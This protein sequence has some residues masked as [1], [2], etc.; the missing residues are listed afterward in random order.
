MQSA[1]DGRAKIRRAKEISNK[2]IYRS[3][4][5]SCVKYRDTGIRA[6]YHL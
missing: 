1:G 3:K 6:P 5:I 4:L 2:L